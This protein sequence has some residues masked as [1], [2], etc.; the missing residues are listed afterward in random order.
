[1]KIR[2]IVQNIDNLQDCI[3][4]HSP[5]VQEQIIDFVFKNYSEMDFMDFMN[6]EFT[7]EELTSIYKKYKIIGDE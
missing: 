1:M 5:K 7:G 4:N 3:K 2:K 6:Y